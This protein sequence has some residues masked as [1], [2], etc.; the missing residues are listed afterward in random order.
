M[1][2]CRR[3]KQG[4]RERFWGKA[5]RSS[6]SLSSGSQ[7]SGSQSSGS[8]S[9]GS[10]SHSSESALL[11]GGG[12]GQQREGGGVPTDCWGKQVLLEGRSWSS[13]APSRGG[14]C[15]P[16]FAL[17]STATSTRS[18]A[19][20]SDSWQRGGTKE[21]LRSCGQ[22]TRS[23]LWGVTVRQWGGTKEWL[24]SCGHEWGAHS[25]LEHGQS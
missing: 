13:W 15:C 21:W 22:G 3:L 1:K 6:G 8:Q 5:C 7:S 2:S 10:Q 16:N 19:R 23:L 20:S 17:S 4:C 18:A 12:S 25:E 11:P 9:S 14:R 24:R